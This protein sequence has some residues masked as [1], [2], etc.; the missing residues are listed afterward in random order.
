MDGRA[1]ALDEFEEELRRPLAIV[2]VFHPWDDPFPDANDRVIVQGGKLLMISWAG[3]DTRSISTGRYDALI[4]DRALAVRDLKAPVLLRFRWEMDRPNLQPSIHSPRDF[5]AAWRHVRSIF[6]RAGATNA[7][8]VWCP[9]AAGFADRTAERYYPGDDQVDYVGADAYAGNDRLAFG[10]LMTPVMAWARRRPRPV[11]VAEFGVQKGDPSYRAH[12]LRDVRAYVSTQPQ[13]KGVVYFLAKQPRG[14]DYTFDGDVP[15]L[16]A[17][18]ALAA[19]PQLSA[20]APGQGP[21]G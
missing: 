8:W 6:V 5:V 17:L 2:N 21:T 11:I 1:E 18:R 12:W 9:L 16:S 14:K 19:A 13:I 10:D 7:A 20:P 4:R 15:A 3:T